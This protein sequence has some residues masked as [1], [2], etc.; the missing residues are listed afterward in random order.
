[1]AHP[2]LRCA[3][4]LLLTLSAVAAATAAHAQGPPNIRWRGT[5]TNL[6]T[7]AAYSPDGTLVA[8]GSNDHRTRVFRA[9]DGELLLTLVQCSGVGCRGPNEV[10]F[11]PDGQLLATV[12]GSLKLWRISDG[13]LVRTINV[14]FADMAFSPDG[15]TIVGT[16]AG[17]GYNSRFVD[18]IRVADGAIT[19]AISGGGVHVAF[20]PDGTKVA[21]VGRAGFD[22]WSLDGTLLWRL[23]GA[24]HA[25]A[26]APD[27]SYVAIAGNGLGDYR[28]DDTIGFFDVG[29]GALQRTLRRTGTVSELTFDVG[30]TML[31]SAGWDPNESF[32]N[33]FTPSTGTI[34]FW[35][36]QEKPTKG[37][38][39]SRVTYDSDTGTGASSLVFAPGSDTFAYVHDM[40]VDLAAMPDVFT[41]P[42]TLTPDAVVIPR[43]GG[44][45]SLHV[46]M[47]SRCGWSATSRVPWITLTGATAGTGPGD[48]TFTVNDESSSAAAGSPTGGYDSIV[49]QITVAGQSFLVNFGG[50]GDGCYFLFQPEQGSIGAGGGEGH[51][52]IYTAPACSWSAASNVSWIHVAADVHVSDGGFVYQVDPSDG[53]PRSG[54]ITVGDTLYT[55]N[56]GAAAG[57]GKD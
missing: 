41:C 7:S 24:R 39:P 17:S 34:R 18:L 52:S 14:G 30:G 43:T 51:V 32:V 16:G 48:V 33:G 20:S 28:Y 5:H 57:T 22:L 50:T 3:R 47:A 6:A 13:T 11:S 31:A 56:Q 40:E 9:S 25:F 53:T 46:G 45:G 26:F 19:K 8:S 12:G 35:N 29:N 27:G 23:S 54:T 10:A 2:P 38:Q 55:V 36:L 15:Q 4:V 1:M 44:A 49:G 42:A 21:A 37:G